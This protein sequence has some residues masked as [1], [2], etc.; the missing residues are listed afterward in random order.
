[1]AARMGRMI[2]ALP[3]REREVLVLRLVRRFT[4]EETAESLGT[5]PQGVLIAEHVAL[6]RLRASIARGCG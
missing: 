6:D 2:A 5:T 3:D 1:M 4:V